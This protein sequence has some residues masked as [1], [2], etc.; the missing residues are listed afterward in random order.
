MPH[1]CL[2]FDV[3]MCFSLL[4][5]CMSSRWHHMYLQ[6]PNSTS[7][8]LAYIYNI[9]LSHTDAYFFFFIRIFTLS[10]LLLLAM[11]SN[12]DARTAVGIIG[13]FLVSRSTVLFPVY[14]CLFTYGVWVL[15][16]VGLG[17]WRSYGFREGDEKILKGQN[18]LL[19]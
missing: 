14:I 5:S 17:Q 8:S 15:V 4:R 16:V 11:F 10:F 3:S 12:E 2:N 1:L 19:S 18:I 7:S 9:C 6:K 13:Q